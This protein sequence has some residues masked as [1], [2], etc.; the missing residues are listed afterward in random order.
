M[1]SMFSRHLWWASFFRES[2][3]KQFELFRDSLQKRLLAS[4]EDIEEEANKVTEEAW[5]RFGTTASPD[6]DP[7]D[8]VE[9]AQEAGLDHYMNL[10]NLKQGLINAYASFCYH[11][12]EQQLFYFHRKELLTQTEEDNYQLFTWAEVRKRLTSHGVNLES[13]VAWNKIQELRLVSNVV[14]HADGPACEDL[15]A[16]RPEMFTNPETRKD[17]M[18]SKMPVELIGVFQPL[19]G[20]DFYVTIQD[21]KEYVEAVIGFWNEMADMLEQQN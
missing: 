17:E 9:P 7:G 3:I 11:L 10:V 1:V 14:K 16:L 15:K 4:F 6:A 21:L 12:F 18:F 5:S 13:F 19:F 2:F 20:E 8:L